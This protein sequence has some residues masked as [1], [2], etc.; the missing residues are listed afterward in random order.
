MNELITLVTPAA[1]A[2]SLADCK[3]DL[4]NDTNFEDD[5]ILSYID[6]ATRLC[7]EVSG[8]SLINETWKLSLNGGFP[9]IRIN[10]T[11]VKSVT[12]IQY[13]DADGVSQT[14][15][16]D[17]FYF[18]VYDAYSELVPKSGFTWPTMEC[19]RDA[20]NITFVAGYGAA[21]ADIPSSITKAIRLLVVHWFENRS[22]TLVGSEAKD[23]PYGVEM[24]LGVERT[25]WIA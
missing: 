11:P 2:V 17:N 20:L 21:S 10:K 15:D 8:R 19:R 22:A 1:L 13:Y 12:E 16:T 5:L 3:L 23:V 4:R 14:I 9:V 6:A 25:G 18:Y 24:L 7:S